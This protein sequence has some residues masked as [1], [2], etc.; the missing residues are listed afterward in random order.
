MRT[1]VTFQTN[2]NNKLNCKFF[3][4]IAPAP[5]FEKSIGLRGTEF[6]A[7]VQDK[8]VKPF[9]VMLIDWWHGP[10]DF[11]PTIYTHLATEQTPEAFANEYMRKKP[12]TPKDIEMGVYLYQKLED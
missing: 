6:E 3:I 7:E 9:R 5:G 4:H 1:K 8:S 11:I 12:D 10:L 2:L